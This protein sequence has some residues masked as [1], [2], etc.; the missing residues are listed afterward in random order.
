MLLT[1]KTRFAADDLFQ[2]AKTLAGMSMMA[3]NREAI[4]FLAFYAARDVRY[5]SKR[6]WG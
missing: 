6:L 5:S 4:D 3:I 2:V 1:R